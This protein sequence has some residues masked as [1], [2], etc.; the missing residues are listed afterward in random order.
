MGAENFEKKREQIFKI[1]KP[2]G[3]M[4]LIPVSREQQKA[5]FQEEFAKKKEKAT[6]E[7]AVKFGEIYKNF[8]E[9]FSADLKKQPS[10]LVKTKLRDKTFV[11]LQKLAASEDFSYLDSDDEL[12]KAFFEFE[13]FLTSEEPIETA[14]FSPLD[15]PKKFGVF[16]SFNVLKN[17]LG[18][19]VVTKTADRKFLQPIGKFLR[20]F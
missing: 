19:K 8:F 11:K 2:D 1:E 9:K 12:L 14:L 18:K 13:N 16:L 6:Q 10:D 3:K 4:N 7:V 17:F 5:Q 15:L 20:W